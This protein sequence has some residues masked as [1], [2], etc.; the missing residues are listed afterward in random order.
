MP[1]RRDANENQNMG[2]EVPV[3][4]QRSR[5]V[6]N[7]DCP[8]HAPVRAHECADTEP[9]AA[10]RACVH[11]QV[12]CPLGSKQQLQILHERMGRRVMY[13]ADGLQRPGH[14]ERQDRTMQVQLQPKSGNRC[15]RVPN[16]AAEL[17]VAVLQAR[18]VPSQQRHMYM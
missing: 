11:V 12:R 14:V 10:G 18:N 1:M 4:V 8:H 7:S 9:Y 2:A 13:D 5:H 3:P 15:R 6:H 17:F 16:Q